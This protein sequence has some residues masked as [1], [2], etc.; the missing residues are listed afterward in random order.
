MPHAVQQQHLSL[1]TWAPPH[2]PL[3]VLQSRPR[4]L[5][6]DQCRGS[7]LVII[8]EVDNYGMLSHADVH[9]DTR[10]LWEGTEV[11]P[12]ASGQ[13]HCSSR[14][15]RKTPPAV[16]LDHDSHLQGQGGAGMP[17]LLVAFKTLKE[18][19]KRTC[20]RTIFSRLSN[21]PLSCR[22]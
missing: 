20:N 15:G 8:G 10:V 16:A 13:F 4:S 22:L 11:M 2:L 1:K 3:L 21:V 9:Q 7:P 18:K 5:I 6:N 12:A 19:S 17:G 14:S